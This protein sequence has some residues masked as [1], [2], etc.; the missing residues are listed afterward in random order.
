MGGCRISGGVGLH[1]S[2]RHDPEG[3][4]VRG[5]A[6]D[7][8]IHSSG[9]EL[10]NELFGET[11]DFNAAAS[12]LAHLASSSAWWTMIKVILLRRAG[13]ENLAGPAACRRIQSQ[14]D[15]PMASTF[16]SLNCLSPVDEPP[17]VRR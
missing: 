4:V 9:L 10:P 15:P 1:R 6:T 17:T 12:V 11:E 13:W 16:G 3:P 5:P 2:P 7:A 14:G 8:F